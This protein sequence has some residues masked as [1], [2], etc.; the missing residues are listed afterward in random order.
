MQTAAIKELEKRGNDAV[1]RLRKEELGK[2]L[3][4]MIN[5]D[6]LPPNQCY[7]EYPDGHLE[8]VTLKSTADH[9]FTVIRVLSIAERNEIM[10]NFLLR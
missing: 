6:S 3:P 9:D 10:H 5:S 7:L 8:L 4:F 2:G 1:K